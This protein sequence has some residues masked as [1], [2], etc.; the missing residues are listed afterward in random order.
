MSNLIHLFIVDED[1]YP[2]TLD[3]SDEQKY[4]ELLDTT[5][6]EAMRWQSIE[7]NMRGFIP[8]LELL[9][10]IVGGQ[11]LLPVCTFNYY[12]HQLIGPEADISGAFGFFSSQ[13]VQDL[14]PLM[15]EN[16]EADID[17][18]ENLKLI[19]EIE[20][21]AGE[22]DPQAYEIVR[23]RYFVTFRDAAEQNKSIVVLI[24]E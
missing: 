23:D 11:G 1:V 6:E 22:L 4:Q 7:L 24:E 12:P 16:Y 17:S 10:A 21:K 18:R 5:Q 15:Q 13:M 9:D 8:A 3:A 14:F 19:D 2:T 20:A